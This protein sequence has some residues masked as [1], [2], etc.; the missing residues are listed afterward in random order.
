MRRRVVLVLLLTT[1]ISAISPLAQATPPHHGCPVGPVDAGSSTI[2]RWELLDESGL[3]PEYADAIL[4]S[5]D[6]N[7]D[8]WVCLMT[9]ILPNDASGDTEWLIA[10]DNNAKEK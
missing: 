5:A 3:P 2:G 10:R 7:G 8:G 1:L 9:Q 6:R 4:A